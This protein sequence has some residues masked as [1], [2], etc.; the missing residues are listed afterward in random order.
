V[1]C[2]TE[3]KVHHLSTSFLL[4]AWNEHF[5]VCSAGASIAT[6]YTVTTV[7]N[8]IA[9]IVECDDN[10]PGIKSLMLTVAQPSCQSGP[11]SANATLTVSAAPAAPRA[12]AANA[13]ACD[14]GHRGMLSANFTLPGGVAAGDSLNLE[15]PSSF[16]GCVLE[17]DS[18]GMWVQEFSF[19]DMQMS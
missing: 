7:N 8:P 3:T 16:T 13:S 18:G 4:C 1:W 14:E 17:T 6:T 5:T 11:Q 10:G 2:I 15:A 9:V 19:F 12:A